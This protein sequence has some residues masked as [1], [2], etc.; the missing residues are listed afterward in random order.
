MVYVILNVCRNYVH[1]RVRNVFP[2]LGVGLEE[3]LLTVLY[4]LTLDSV[5]K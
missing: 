1:V 2:G 4:N 3:E 5:Q